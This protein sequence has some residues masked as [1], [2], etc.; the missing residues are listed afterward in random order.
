MKPEER[1]FEDIL[2]KLKRAEPLLEN[3]KDIENEVISRIESGFKDKKIP[4]NIFNYLFGWAYVAWARS[5]LVTASFLLV[6]AF[7]IQ[8]SLILK[9]IRSLEENAILNGSQAVT[10]TIFNP[11]ERVLF[12]IA[13]RRFPAG[14]RSVTEKQVNK[15]IDSYDKLEMKY[16]DLLK[17]IEEDPELKKMVESRLKEKDKLK[18]KL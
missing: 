10:H 17:M 8:Q 3:A 2:N 18:L 6:F 13:N 5:A 1:K 7:V 14:R 4:V 9:R 16:K 11:E 12:E 15:L